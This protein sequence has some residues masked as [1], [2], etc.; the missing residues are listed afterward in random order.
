VTAIW[1]E[2]DDGW[3]LLAPAGFADEAALHSLV[4]RSPDLL[5]LAGSPR[6]AVVGREVLLGGNRAD[7][8]AIEPTGRPCLIEVKL[9]VNSEARR[10]VV[11]QIL[12]YAAYLHR[13]TPEQLEGD[14]LGAH[15]RERGFPTL[16]DAAQQADQDGIFDAASFRETLAAAL[17]TG[18]MRLV[19]VLDQAP[20]ELVR[21]V[22]FLQSVTEAL[23]VD[24]VTVSAYRVGDRRVLVPQRIEPD[25]QTREHAGEP[26]ARP[27]RGGNY[28]PGTAGFIAAIDQAPAEHR[29]MLRRLAEWAEE[30]GRL[31]PV[32]LTTYWGQR[33]EITLLPR[34][35]PDNGGLV[36]IWNWLGTPTLSF[37]RS[38]FERRA[39]HTLSAVEA[40]IAPM[41]LGQ[42]NTTQTITEELLA[43]LTAAYQEASR[44][45]APPRT[46]EL[47]T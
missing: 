17:E 3:E 37:W 28:E 27:K 25:R 1:S 7:L 8:V 41:A 10:A 33:G 36:T 31:G 21:T 30:L 40:S 26:V 18:G 47:A 14:V 5:P 4:E 45:G 42:G 9:A 29:P 32:T 11:A 19:L 38:V 24:L 15:L 44:R 43:A 20:A 2:T 46:P 35:Q 6:L 12:S 16:A 22:G 23:V 39:P 34:I 13:M